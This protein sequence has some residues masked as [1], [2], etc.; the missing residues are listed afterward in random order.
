VSPSLQTCALLVV[1]TLLPA[2]ARG[3]GPV[4]DHRPIGCIEAGHFPRMTVRLGPPAAISRARLYFR[5]QGTPNWYYLGMQAEGNVFSGVLPRPG[6]SMKRIEYY[7]EATDK[8]LVTTKSAEFSAAVVTRAGECP[9]GE[10]VAVALTKGPSEKPL[11]STSGAPASPP[12]FWGEGHLGTKTLLIGG[13]VLGGVG[14]GLLASRT[15]PN[16]APTLGGI[17]AKPTLALR[18]ITE[19]SFAARN[20]SDPDGD[21]LTYVWDF[22]DG[23]SATGASQFHVYV[24]AGI[25]TVRLHLKDARGETA[26]ATTTVTVKSVTGRWEGSRTQPPSAPGGGSNFAPLPITMVMEQGVQGFGPQALLSCLYTEH[27]PSWRHTAVPDGGAVVAPAEVICDTVSQRCPLDE[28]PGTCPS[29]RELWFGHLSPDLDAMAGH[30]EDE[31]GVPIGT[32]TLSR[33]GP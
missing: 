24:I 1:A 25:L 21:A 14:V 29:Q 13:A 23:A 32:F 15:T 11:A 12:G 6:K 27:S 22:G 19:V 17:E 18:Q 28:G 9:A 20:A 8:A 10:S 33:T 26:D 31:N 5:A 7:V 2:L 30:L 4:I 16:H 3:E